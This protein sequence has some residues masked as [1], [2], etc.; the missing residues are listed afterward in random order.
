LFDEASENGAEAGGRASP[1]SGPFPIVAVGASAGGLEAL[2]MLLSHV[3][4]CG[5]AILILQHLSPNHP[6]ALAQIVGRVSSMP[7]VPMSHGLKLQPDVVYTNLPAHEV[8]VEDG[9]IVL[10]ALSDAARHH[11]I[12]VLFRSLALDQGTNA[13]A[14]VLSGAGSDGSLGVRAIKEEGGITFAEDPDEAAQPGMPQSSID[15]SCID[16]V[17][18]PSAIGDELMRL[19]SRPQLTNRRLAQK[20][21]P[22]LL[23]KIFSRLRHNSGVDFSNYKPTTVERRIGRRMLLQ[24]I[25][26]PSE[27]LTLL[28]S[29]RSEQHALYEDL[30]IGVTCFFRDRE[31]FALI[32]DT[33]LPALLAQRPRDAPL[34]VWIPGC[35]TGE[36]AYSLGICI[37]EQIERLA[38]G[39]AL[40]IFATDVN[41]QALVKARH[42]VYPESIELDVSA[43]RL[44]RFFSRTDKN[45]Y[46]VSRK[47]RDII[48]FARHNLGKDP[49][50]SRLDLVSCRNVLIYLQPAL[51]K[52]AMRI[53]HYAL[54]PQ[55]YLLLGT[56]E[57]VG[58]ASDL[59]SLLDRKLKL[60]AK[61]HAAAPGVFDFAFGRSKEGV[62][63]VMSAPPSDRKPEVSLQQ[64]VD[65][66]ILDKYGPPGVLIDE[67]LNILQFRGQC[68]RFFAPS[69]GAA[70]LSILR[71]IRPEL[72]VP[73]KMAVQCVLSEKLQTS[74]DPIRLLDSTHGEVCMDV[75]SVEAAGHARCLLVLF[76]EVASVDEP[77]SSGD[78]TEPGRSPAE[79]KRLRELERELSSTKEYLETIVQELATSNE[80][81]QSSNEELQSSNEEL[82]STNEELE[83][84]KEELQAT[85]E[86]LVTVNEE[87]QTRIA[88]L[89]VA[90][91]DVV[92]LLMNVSSPVILVGLDLRIRRFSA[93]AERLV[94]LITSDIG[95]PVS[96]LGS[97][98]NAPQIEATVSEAIST[99]RPRQ[100]RVRASNGAWYNLRTVPYQ[101]ADR[102]VRGAVIELLPFPSM[103]D[104][105]QV[106]E[107]HEL[108]S[109]LLATLPHQLLLID[110]RLRVVWA[111]QA[112]LEA[113]GD[114]AEYIG[115][116]LE[117]VF[118]REDQQ[119]DLWRRIKATASGGRTFEPL[120]LEH[121]WPAQA[122][123]MRRWTARFI[124]QQDNRRALTLF[125]IETATP[126]PG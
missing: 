102:G 59:F 78:T 61:K 90:N 37:L 27:Y 95:R 9:A 49:P 72:L 71:M 15:T 13:I 106:M 104:G 60:Y 63:T 125:V 121:P 101:T 73:L 33:I 114:D 98:L 41:E 109:K 66:K 42:G 91:D 64:L 43:E 23:A 19:A 44:Q 123:Q 11:P 56:A 122:A 97:V 94:N 120:S 47:L 79:D 1:Q 16:F 100:L 86:E 54:K 4:K 103:E 3:Q 67:N 108:V 112:L 28:E 119:P 51:Q 105:E 110:Q 36:E 24:R 17:L 118:D 50:F 55:G 117:Q 84:S 88:Q 12:D 82:Q 76:R 89:G 8:R 65:R 115:H 58:D 38:P 22:A 57:S 107:I 14:V 10:R 2:E 126:E 92:N 5:M 99:M 96:Y 111:N 34:R 68:A 25:D 62:A 29:N 77:T 35:A 74:T 85:N 124:P 20:L 116:S 93:A 26:R 113:W 53:F 81:L 18:G 48:V 21:A 7:V 45:G 80:E 6:S 69:P 39:M 32:A 40:Q 30:L 87:L 31:P 46:Q 83:T 75:L 52:R 70:T